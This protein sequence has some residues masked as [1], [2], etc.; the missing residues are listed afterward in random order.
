MSSTL[1]SQQQST[2]M[3]LPERLRPQTLEEVVGQTHLKEGLQKL[4]AAEGMISFVL[5]GPPGTG[6]T[7]FA[8]IFA[9]EKQM[10]FANLSAVSDGVKAIRTVAEEAKARREHEGR[11]TILFLDEIHALSR[12]QQDVL[13]PF[14]ENGTFYLIGA[15]TENPSFSLNPALL[16]R[17]RI[18]LTKRLQE[19][20]LQLLLDRAQSLLQSTLQPEL[21]SIL[22]QL[23]NGDARSM[24]TLLE[25]ALLEEVQTK[26]ELLRLADT[27]F[28]KG[29][30]D[31]KYWVISAFIKSMRASDENA[32]I[33]YLARLLES[34]EDPRYIA[35]RMMIFASEDVGQADPQSLPLATAALTATEKIGMPE[36]RI[37]LAQV[38]THLANA[39]K[40][41][42]S[43]LAIDAALAEVRQSGNLPIPIH[44]RNAPT[45]FLKDL[46]FGK[47][48]EY[49]HNGTRNEQNL[50]K[51]MK[52][53]G[54]F[55]K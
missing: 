29:G 48:Y 53:K 47:G 23:A 13:L 18:F 40:N 32:A 17:V 49:P 34:G 39:P 33:Y 30:V 27:C 9:R 52:G 28:V 44:L 22:L 8:R 1:F 31:E 3:P 38:A 6:K 5:W 19:E 14:L 16:S 4:L 41:N 55:E 10:H 25:N 54:F 36:V 42:R 2:N 26:S 12:N 7:T 45:K 43:Y 51:E 21:Q 24:L 46:G 37:I 15:T 11:R 35:R 50:P 20:E